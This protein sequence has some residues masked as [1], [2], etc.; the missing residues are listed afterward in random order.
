MYLFIYL[1]KNTFEMELLYMDVSVLKRPFKSGLS[2]TLIF[3][4]QVAVA[5]KFKI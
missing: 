4:H 1:I 5:T 3:C 2:L